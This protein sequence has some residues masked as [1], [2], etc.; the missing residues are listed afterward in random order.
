TII[1]DTPDEIRAA[2]EPPSWARQELETRVLR[3]AEFQTSERMLFLPGNIYCDARLIRALAERKDDAALI[4]GDFISG[5]AVIDDGNYASVPQRIQ[6]RRI[7]ILRAV[8]V[9][10]YIVGMRRNLPPRCFRISPEATRIVLDTGQPKTL[11]LPAIVQSPI[12]TFIMRGLCRTNITPNQITF[13]GILVSLGATVLFASG[14]LWWGM[15]PALAIGVIDGL[16]GK[17]ARIKIE[18]TEA[19]EWEHTIDY[20]LEASWWAGLAFWFQRSG[21]LPSA[22]IWFFIILLADAIDRLA[23]RDAKLRIGRLLDDYAPFDRFVRLIGARRDVYI[24]ALAIGLWL[25]AAAPTYRLCAIW[26]AASALVHVLRALMIR[27]R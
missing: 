13:F 18:T 17:Q 1:S 15:I 5:A 16:D 19:G 27:W 24:W 22:W 20:F 12:E 25:G 23:K 26:G 4:D 21:Q 14:R 9:P 6:E 11:D 2:T 10:S 3:R 8:D 7:A